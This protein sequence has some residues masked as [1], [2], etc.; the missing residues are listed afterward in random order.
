M[1]ASGQDGR[2]SKMD[3]WTI[4]EYGAWILSALFGGLILVDLAR[5]DATYDDD[6]L[7]S[8]REGEIELAQERHEL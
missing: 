5:I 6:L 1:S 2:G 4:L 8:S 3:T 7:T